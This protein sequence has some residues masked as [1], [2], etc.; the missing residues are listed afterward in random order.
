MVVA[1]VVARVVLARRV[2]AAPLKRVAAV[3][4]KKA[5]V[6]LPKRVAAT[7]AVA[8]RKK[9]DTVPAKRLAS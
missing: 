1:I 4:R 3:L 5:A 8:L 6:A 9:V 7:A 2:A